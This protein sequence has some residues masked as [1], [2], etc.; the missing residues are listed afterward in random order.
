MNQK[1]MQTIGRKPVTLVDSLETYNA[2]KN[3]E[4]RAQGPKGHVNTL[5]KITSKNN[6][7]ISVLNEYKAYFKNEI[8][9]TIHLEIS[10]N[11]EKLNSLVEDIE[12]ARDINEQNMY[13]SMLKYGCQT[14]GIEGENVFSHAVRELS[15]TI[16]YSTSGISQ[17]I[18]PQLLEDI[19]SYGNKLLSKQA[20]IGLKGYKEIVKGDEFA[21]FF[22]KRFRFLVEGEMLYIYD[23]FKGIY[24]QGK[25]TIGRICIGYL[26]S[27]GSDLWTE[28]SEKKLMN[29]LIRTCTT[30]GSIKVNP[31]KI[32]FV[33]QT[34]DLGKLTFEG[35]SHNNYLF[36][37]SPVAYDQNA[38][39]PIFSAFLKSI[40]NWKE[41]EFI[42]EYFGYVISNDFDGNMLLI[43]YGSGAN[44]KSSLFSILSELIGLENVSSVTLNE[45]ST[46][47][48][49]QPL[50]GKRLNY[51]S[52]G[53][54]SPK[55]VER[56]K[57]ITG[58]ESILVERKNLP[59]L[60][61]KLPTKL[62]FLMNNLV[63]F[64]DDSHALQR[65]LI[66][67]PFSKT[68]LP[69]QQD[70]KL[71]TKLMGELPGILNFAIAGLDQLRKNNHMFTQSDAMK[72]AH[73]E[74]F[75]KSTLFEHYFQNKL[76]CNPASRILKTD[77]YAD[78]L[79]WAKN[80]GLPHS[81]YHSNLKLFWS[82][83]SK[84]LQSHYNQTPI[85]VKSNGN[86]Y[87]QGYEIII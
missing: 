4:V 41:I 54:I 13:I 31:E 33:N 21:E 6:M 22:K 12:K 73:A 29:I 84:E 2:I 14:F 18:D 23:H 75:N 64:E 81:Q 43:A 34:L 19:Q 16:S 68:F 28:Y 48:G 27:L 40:F 47:F 85:F 80:H 65:R 36:S 1:K 46:R 66:L 52:E 17:T 74:Y 26:N 32:A 63:K 62:C 70:P 76:S 87:I 82:D 24:S 30:L 78:I 60:T 72:L 57:A 79:L 83:L 86:R 67:L 44:G 25:E 45:M 55:S 9:D 8:K 58:K 77:L 3:G 39:C 38:K 50:L 59:A 10:N 51:S 49:L 42:K 37:S 15:S 61:C 35:H 20:G 11:F 53:E 56:V 7:S 69:H 71:K 5:E